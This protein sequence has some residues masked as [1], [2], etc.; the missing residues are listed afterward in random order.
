MTTHSSAPVREETPHAN[1]TTR[2]ATVLN[3]LKQR[4]LSVLNDSS[5][6]PESRAILR[7]ALE[8]NDPW[9]A[10]MVKQADAVEP[11]IDNLPE[12][13][14]DA[15]GNMIEVLVDLICRP[16]DEP[17]TKSVAL[18]VLLS[19]LERSTESKALANSAKHFAFAH[20]GDVSFDNMVEAQ[21]AAF[22]A[23][24]FTWSAPVP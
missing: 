12:R 2:T 21:I 9:L 23:E 22:E 6:D 5:I 14:N 10:K 15:A 1:R 18:L 20:C 19:T 11:V 16:G 7:Y 17:K 8:T 4:A 3:V 24:L 13:G